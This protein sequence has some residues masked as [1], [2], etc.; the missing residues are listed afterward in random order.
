MAPQ[1]HNPLRI[2]IQEP[3]VDKAP[4]A[5]GP[6]LCHP[7]SPRFPGFCVLR[8]RH[9][10]GRIEAAVPLIA[11]PLRRH[12][13]YIQVWPHPIHHVVRPPCPPAAAQRGSDLADASSGAGGL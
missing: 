1:P 7:S 10:I 2:S 12:R 13:A 8:C 4:D 9:A 5:G 3:S 11:I 6:P